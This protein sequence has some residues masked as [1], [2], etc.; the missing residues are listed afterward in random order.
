M[1]DWYS[2]NPVGFF[3]ILCLIY[4]CMFFIKR[5]FILN[6]I[7]AFEI[8]QERGEM[9]IMDLFLNLQYLS[10]PLFL[11][12]KFTITSFTVWV[13]CFLFG[14][15]ITFAQ[16][17][18]LIMILELVFIIPEILKIFWF[19]MFQTDPDYQDVI[20]FYPLSLI[21]LFDYQ[22][23]NP[24]WLYPLKSLNVFEIL[25]WG[26]LI[27]GIYWVSGKKLNQARNI[28][29]SSYV[30][31]FLLWLAYFIMAYR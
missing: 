1:D 3:L 20:A 23:L 27:A 17:W 22:S 16:L 26:L 13:G 18:K 6:E 19:T 28:V 30:L 9:W 29:L 24:K 8:M 12:W 14:Y 15:R 25:Y 2:M 5:L 31:F 11:A 10:I 4:G 21:N 7:A